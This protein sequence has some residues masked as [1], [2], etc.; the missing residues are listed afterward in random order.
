MEEEDEEGKLT[1][2]KEVDGSFAGG[3]F[4]SSDRD[5]EY[6][7]EVRGGKSASVGRVMP[8]EQL[9]KRIQDLSISGVRAVNGGL[10]DG[11]RDP[12]TGLA[13]RMQYGGLGMRAYCM[14]GVSYG[15]VRT[16][17]RRCSRS[18]T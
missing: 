13:C 18:L 4:I 10:E 8:V 12:K 17:S 15:V 3:V 16:T 7:A 14:R 2:L 9:L 5:G 6:I 1:D 11:T